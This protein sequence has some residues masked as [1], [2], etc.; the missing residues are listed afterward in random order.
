MSFYSFFCAK[1]ELDLRSKVHFSSE[2]KYKSE[3][4]SAVIKIYAFLY[5]IIIKK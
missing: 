1:N 3:Y 2:K 4:K 5:Q